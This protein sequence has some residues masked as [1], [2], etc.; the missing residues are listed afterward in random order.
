MW[1]GVLVLQTEDPH[2]NTSSYFEIFRQGQIGPA[3]LS[4]T[5]ARIRMARAVA[6]CVLLQP[7]MSINRRNQ[8]M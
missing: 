8:V 5:P 1:N 6:L 7:A 4:L 3:L 2:S